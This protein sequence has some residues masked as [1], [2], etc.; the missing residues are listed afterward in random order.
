M[1]LNDFKHIFQSGTGDSTLLLLHGTG[2]D[3]GDLIP[4]ARQLGWTGHILSLRGRV[5]EQGMPRFFKRLSFGV[6]D[7][8]DL[9]LRTQELLDYLPV[10]AAHYGF[11]RQQLDS[12]GYSNGANLIGSA[13]LR[14]P[15][16]FRKSVLLRPMIPFQPEK[17]ATEAPGEVLL[18]SG[19]NDPTVPAGMPE[20]YAQLLS[21]YYPGQ[22]RLELLPGGHGLSQADLSMAQGFLLGVSS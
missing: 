16:C 7:L 13:L 6:F 12:L 21:A 8:E 2:A 9:A 14:A 1:Q 19:S 4:L 11:D 5:S 10:A 22:V 15:G 3:E 18:L 17:P 20:A